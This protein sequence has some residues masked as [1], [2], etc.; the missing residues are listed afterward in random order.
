MAS[1]VFTIEAG[2]FGLSLVDTAAGGYAVVLA[3]AGQHR[4][5]CCRIDDYVDGSL[6][7]YTC[8]ITSGALTASPN[9]TT[10]STPATFCGPEETTTNVGV[11]SYSCDV[12]FLQDPDLMNGINRYLFQYDTR[13]GVLLS[14]V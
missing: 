5:R 3:D 2:K 9:T 12:T 4:H 13:R 10:D 11:T 7:D 6:G 1:H 8:Q 14:R